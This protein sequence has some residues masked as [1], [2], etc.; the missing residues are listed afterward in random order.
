MAKNTRSN[1][2]FEH[3]FADILSLSLHFNFDQQQ[4]SE[5]NYIVQIDIQMQ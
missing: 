5:Q 4:I 1:H 2:S 3:L